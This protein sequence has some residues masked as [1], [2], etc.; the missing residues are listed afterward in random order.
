[1]MNEETLESDRHPGAV[2]FTTR[3][4]RLMKALQHLG[5]WIV[6]GTLA[7]VA[8][9]F[10]LRLWHWATAR[11][12]NRE[13]LVHLL[14]TPGVEDRTD[15]DCLVLR[16]GDGSWI[17]IRFVEGNDLPRA[18]ARDSGGNWFET[19]RSISGALGHYRFWQEPRARAK[20][21]NDP[22]W[23]E[24]GFL[25]LGLNRQLDEIEQSTSLA[26]ARQKLR[27]LGFE[28]FKP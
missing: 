4:T 17:A 15:P 25:K 10:G 26:Q 8:V 12:A 16:P 28:E 24:Q 14:Q 20:A 9:W 13:A 1:M 3:R 19:D 7:V 21:T 27:E 23:S 6:F 22:E 11:H 2:T 18:V 5:A